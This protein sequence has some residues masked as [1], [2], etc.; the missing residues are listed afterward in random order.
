MSFL[1]D[2][3]EVLERLVAEADARRL[4]TGPSR[5]SCGTTGQPVIS[6]LAP[7][8]TTDFLSEDDQPFASR[9][10]SGIAVDDSFSDA[11]VPSLQSPDTTDALFAVWGID[12]DGNGPLH[13][14]VG[15]TEP[16]ASGPSSAAACSPGGSGPRSP[17]R[18]TAPRAHR[19]V[20][21]FFPRPVRIRCF[22]HRQA[23]IRAKLHDDEAA[24][25]IAHLSAVRD[26]PTLDAARAAVDA[27]P[28]PAALGSLRPSPSS[29]RPESR[30]SPSTR[31]R[32]VTASG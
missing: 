7:S 32:S 17:S 30:S 28:L 29:R 2:N 31:S 23:D 5:A 14:T 10:L 13:P 25:V 12:A 3:S 18:P 26:A 16:E 1:E 24:E 20:E 6:R 27:S 9:D 22:L 4:S 15:N 21:A 8:E 19:A 11:I